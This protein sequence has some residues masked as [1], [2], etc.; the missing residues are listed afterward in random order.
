[1]LNASR[2]R[3]ITPAS[4]AFPYSWHLARVNVSDMPFRCR[5]EICLFNA[6]EVIK[7]KEEGW[8]W[9]GEQVAN[10]AY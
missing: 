4:R 2:R 5:L 8:R 10:Y 7:D 6:E 3:T 1:M 9:I